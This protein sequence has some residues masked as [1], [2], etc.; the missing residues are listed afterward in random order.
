MKKQVSLGELLV[1]SIALF[2][3]GM[4]AY[5]NIKTSQSGQEVRINQME[6]NYKG[7]QSDLKEIK[8]SETQILIKLEDKVNRKQW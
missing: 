2:L 5:V 1:A 4:G 3:A 7:I 6:Q 8:G